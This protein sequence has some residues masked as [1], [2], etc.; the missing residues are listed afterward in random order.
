MTK[1]P[2]IVLLYTAC[3]AEVVGQ[4]RCHTPNRINPPGLLSRSSTDSLL[5]ISIVFHNLHRTEE[6]QIDMDQV[7][8]QLRSL[9]EDFQRRNADTIN[10]PSNFTMVS[11]DCGVS[12]C[13][14]S[15]DPLGN[16]STGLNYRRTHVPSIG[17]S[18]FYFQTA[19][20]GQDIWDPSRY[21]NVWVCE[22][23]EKGDIAGFTDFPGHSPID[24]DGIVIDYRFFGHEG[25]A[26]P[27]FDQGRTL[28]HEIGH[29]LGLAHIWGDTTSCEI[30]DGLK[31]TPSQLS[32]YRGCPDFP[33]ASCGS[34]D[35]FMNFMDLTDDACMNLF[36][37]QQRDVLRSTLMTSRKSLLRTQCGITVGTSDRNRNH[38]ITI[39]PNP[40]VLPYIYILDFSET[41]KKYEI[42]TTDGQSIQRGFFYD[43]IDI[44][45]LSNGFYFLKLEIE[46]QT[47]LPSF[48]K[49]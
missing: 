49:L 31:D 25:S 12:F 26:L 29:W 5:T 37:M 40:S 44:L 32:P 42:L 38:V 18:Q 20:G 21:L 35:M 27:P 3:V 8:D 48:I 47:F 15:Q 30:D 10:T 1:I 4:T 24:R 46:G 41:S 6:Q 2:L 39:F 23:S 43:K 16:P 7:H 22:I 14:A 45:S 34:Q 11:A 9:N 36:T 17:L 33:Q 28:T 19:E 13:L